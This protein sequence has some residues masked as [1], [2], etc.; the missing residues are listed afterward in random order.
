MLNY[1]KLI[2]APLLALSLFFNGCTETETETTTTESP[3]P[4]AAESPAE[5][6]ATE[7]SPAAESPSETEA[8]AEEIDLSAIIGT[9]AE[10]WMPKA[11][12]DYKLKEDMTP[13]EA[14][15]EIA[16]AEAISEF[17][18]SEVKV[19]DVPGIQKYEFYFAKD[20]SGKPTQLKNVTL[21]FDPAL[22]SKVSFEEM[23]KALSEKYGEVEPDE[24]EKGIVT[25]SG[26]SL[27]IAQLTKGTNDFEGYEFEI[28]VPE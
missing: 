3:S 26:P 11:L 23:A 5:S 17:G 18:F 13:E 2:F 20:D 10:G 24:I 8:G 4:V 9:K 16:G 25:W 6:P 12:A 21:V 28:A 15:K 7:E 14:A 27:S 1:K 22:K 19:E